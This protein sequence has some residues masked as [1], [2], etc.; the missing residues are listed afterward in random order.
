MVDGVLAVRSVDQL[1]SLFIGEL[2]GSY[3]CSIGKFIHRRMGDCTADDLS[4]PDPQD[5]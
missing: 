5:S 1:L 2:S 3:G 4:Q